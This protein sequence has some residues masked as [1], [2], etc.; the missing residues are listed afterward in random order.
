MRHHGGQVVAV[1]EVTFDL[2]QRAVGVA[3]HRT[4]GADD[5]LLDIAK[6]VVHAF[7]ARHLGRVQQRSDRERT[8]GGGDHCDAPEVTPLEVRPCIAGACRADSCLDRQ[9]DSSRPRIPHCAGG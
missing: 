4:V 1:I 3:A 8:M 6:H 9:L 5:C 7:D 2:G